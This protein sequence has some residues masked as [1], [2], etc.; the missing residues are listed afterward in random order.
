MLECAMFYMRVPQTACH[1]VF[2][3]EEHTAVFQIQVAGRLFFLLSLC[4]INVNHLAMISS[5][6]ELINTMCWK[7]VIKY[8]WPY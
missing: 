2:W 6:I 4:K 5:L 1:R 3:N 7:P 8:L